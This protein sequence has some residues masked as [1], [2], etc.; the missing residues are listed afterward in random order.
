M[1]KRELPPNQGMTAGT[2]L[3]PR[4]R[5]SNTTSSVTP[6]VGGAEAEIGTEGEAAVE[7]GYTGPAEAEVEVET[8]GM[9]AAHNANTNN[10]RGK[11]R[12]TRMSRHLRLHYLLH[13]HRPKL[14]ASNSQFGMTAA[15]SMGKSRRQR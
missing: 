11:D 6:A 12:A 7:I 9:N 2:G 3:V 8:A 4:D 1:I 10:T 13:Y 15:G 5:P 14:H